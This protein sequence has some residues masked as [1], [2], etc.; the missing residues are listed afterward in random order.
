MIKIAEKSVAKKVASYLLEIE[1]IKLKPSEPF[2]WASGW[3]SPIYCDNRLSLSFPKVRKYITKELT[4]IIKNNYENID[5]IAGV[6]TAGLPQGTLVADQLEL[7][8]SY[9]RSSAKKHGMTN[10]IEGKIDEG[11][12][13][14]L[15]E[16]LISTGGSSIDAAL[17]LK[18]INATPLAI[19]SIFTY[20]FPIAETN[21]AN[22]NISL[23]SLCNYDTLIEVAKEENKIS[24]SQIED[25]KSWKDAPE[26]WGL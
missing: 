1:A 23:L 6:A 19:V 20:G 17:A 16:D 26:K 5:C 15:I 18:D 13:V 14:V 7:P 9:I 8:F 21:L 2:T 4:T 11:E 25:L 10:K 12:K 3:K 22:A 24:E